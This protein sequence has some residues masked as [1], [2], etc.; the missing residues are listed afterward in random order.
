MTKEPAKKRGRPALPPGEGRRNTLNLRI[1]NDLKARMEGSAKASGRSVSQEA[2]FR[3]E[4]SFI[5]EDTMYE[6]FGGEE[7]S[8]LMQ[9]FA[10]SFQTAEPK[11]ADPNYRTTAVRHFLPDQ[12]K[13]S[14][15]EEAREFVRAAV[16][17]RMEMTQG[18]SLRVKPGD[19]KEKR[20]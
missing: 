18:A 5:A 7:W 11:T 13:R 20:K 6:Q 4:R 10:L 14:A 1:T 15:L 17:E 3:L 2:E 8:R 9:F 16:K 12:P 19:E